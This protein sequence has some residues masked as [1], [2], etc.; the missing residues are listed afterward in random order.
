[1]SRSVFLF[2]LFAI[3]ALVDAAPA[4]A[5]RGD[6]NFDAGDFDRRLERTVA[7]KGRTDP[8]AAVSVAVM[9]GDRLVYQGAAGCAEFSADGTECVREM[10]AASKFRAGPVLEIAHALGRVSL[11]KNERP[12]R[13]AYSVSYEA[14]EN[15]ALQFP[16]A[17]LRASVVDLARLARRLE[18]LPDLTAAQSRGNDAPTNGGSVDG[19]FAAFG[20]GVQQIAGT[21]EFLS[22]STLIGR[23]GNADGLYS[24]AWLVKSDAAGAAEDGVAIA[25]AAT[26]VKGEPAKGAHLAFNLIEERLM[27]TAMDA[28]IAADEPRPFDK[29][30]DA[31]RD[32]DDALAA[33]KESGKRPLLV[34]GANWCHDSRGLA[35]KFQTERL[36]R[37]IEGGYELVW[38]DV[39][40][41]DRN[42][43][44]AR[45]F[46]VERI[47]GTPTI[48]ILSADGSILN[49]DSVNDWRTADSRSID[50]AI[51]YFGAYAA[52]D[53]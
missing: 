1:M 22:G 46:G 15:P 17:D 12:D 3:A 13:R 5:S 18:T 25:F 36:S 31:M 33:A 16:Q 27:R 4:A 43:D 42:L 41:K 20:P 49:A 39:G 19:R 2:S 21:K 29:H 10:T 45:R 6:R 40:R 28:A 24:G 34:L 48:L 14:E 23:S 35:K 30:A 37:I 50:E 51:E 52:S 47:I 44:V 53:E 7:G 26:G 9:I 38:V 32:V 11:E 8:V